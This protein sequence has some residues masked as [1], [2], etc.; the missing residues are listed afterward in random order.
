M[1]ESRFLYILEKVSQLTNMLWWLVVGACYFIVYETVI[2]LLNLDLTGQ[3]DALLTFSG[4]GIVIVL[5][6]ISSI[7]HYSIEYTRKQDI[8]RIENRINARETLRRMMISYD[9][10]A[11]NNVL[12]SDELINHDYYYS[13]EALN[14]AN[15][16]HTT[17]K[18]YRSSI[19]FRCIDD[20]DT[21]I[22]NI[23]DLHNV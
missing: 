12:Y 16:Y 4:F 22:N 6:I 23:E 2:L 8:E 7:V 3:E 10:V 9:D 13:N 19:I 20:S 11:M 14:S 21:V 5:C 1:I 17:K 18:K 15:Y